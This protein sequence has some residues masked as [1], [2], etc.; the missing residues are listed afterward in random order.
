MVRMHASF[1]PKGPRKKI[2][3]VDEAE[4]DRAWRLVATMKKQGIYTTISPYWAAGGHTGTAASWGHRGLWRQ[5]RSL[6]SPV[7]Q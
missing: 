6:G 7:L 3:E 5:G 4:I 1:S 2:T